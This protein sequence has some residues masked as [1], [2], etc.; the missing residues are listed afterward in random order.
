MKKALQ[1]FWVLVILVLSTGMLIGCG[2]TRDE[3]EG[4]DEGL[5]SMFGW[6]IE[7]AWENTVEPER[8]KIAAAKDGINGVA[9]ITWASSTEW[10]GCDLWALLPEGVDYGEYDGISFKVKLS[11]AATDFTFMLVAVLDDEDEVTFLH[12]NGHVWGTK[13]T[14]ITV[15]RSFTMDTI[16]SKD[17]YWPTAEYYT[18][19]YEKT[20]KQFLTETKDIERKIYLSTKLGSNNANLKDLDISFYLDDVGFYKDSDPTNVTVVWDFEDEG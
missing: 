3:G 4:E 9:K 18:G 5:Q 16:D 17:Y 7:P 15:T 6:T 12:E 20:L 8:L 11:T 2:G 14:W 13:D 10:R 19:T 1:L